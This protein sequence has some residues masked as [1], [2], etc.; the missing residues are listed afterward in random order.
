MD[1]G[2]EREGRY[3]DPDNDNGH[4]GSG[5]EKGTTRLRWEEE[6]QGPS[7]SWEAGLEPCPKPVRLSSAV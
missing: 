7:R 6:C 5:V 1:V 4:A 3:S 2:E